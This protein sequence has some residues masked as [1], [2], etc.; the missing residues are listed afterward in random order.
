L[1]FF[2]SHNKWKVTNDMHFKETS[3]LPKKCP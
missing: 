1:L 3:T 2:P